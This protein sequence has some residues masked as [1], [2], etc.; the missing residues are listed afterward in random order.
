MGDPLRVIA[1][2]VP[3]LVELL[4]RADEHQYHQHIREYEC[5]EGGDEPKSVEAGLISG[6][7][8]YINGDHEECSDGN[9][10]AEG[11]EEQCSDNLRPCGTHCVSQVG[12]VV[13][14]HLVVSGQEVGIKVGSCY[15]GSP[16][17]EVTLSLMLT[18]RPSVHS[19]DTV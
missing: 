3:G 17:G 8:A 9:E 4:L 7:R 13:Q 14:Q 5:N 2:V 10:D 18:P 1:R 15:L 19:T 11:E 16:L 6:K 12:Y